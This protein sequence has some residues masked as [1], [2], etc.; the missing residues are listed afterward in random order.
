[1]P[2]VFL[3]ARLESQ[4]TKTPYQR[5]MDRIR[6]N[7]DLDYAP[8]AGCQPK[9]LEFCC[10]RCVYG[11]GEHRADLSCGQIVSSTRLFVDEMNARSRAQQ[12]TRR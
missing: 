3:P 11:T 8:R 5:R 2:E 1:M 7:Y 9:T 12:I 6:S 4:A 10:E